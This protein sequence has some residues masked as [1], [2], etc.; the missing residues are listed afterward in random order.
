[1]QEIKLPMTELWFLSFC[2]SM[3]NDK[4]QARSFASSCAFQK[5]KKGIWIA[6]DLKFNFSANSFYQF[7]TIC[8]KCVE[9][10]QIIKVKLEN[11]SRFPAWYLTIRSR[12]NQW[13]ESIEHFIGGEKYSVEF[14]NFQFNRTDGKAS[15]L[16]IQQI[17]YN[18]KENMKREGKKHFT[19]WTMRRR[20]QI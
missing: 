15:V 7:K 3:E 2:H 6:K 4:H 11:H 13:I 12:R 10:M 5:C 16:N 20:F 17:N 9:I 18:S 19:F 1:M 8:W 14:H